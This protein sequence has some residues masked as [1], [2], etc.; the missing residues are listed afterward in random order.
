MFCKLYKYKLIIHS[1]KEKLPR[2]EFKRK[3]M[4]E[5]Y[6]NIPRKQVFIKTATKMMCKYIADK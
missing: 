3:D 1:F 2:S 6:K 5:V 4:T